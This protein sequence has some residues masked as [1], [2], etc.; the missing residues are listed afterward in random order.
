MSR[1]RKVTVSRLLSSPLAGIC[2]RKSKL[3]ANKAMA[4]GRGSS[5][6]EMSFLRKK[7]RLYPS[8]K[9][10]YGVCA[11]IATYFIG[12]ILL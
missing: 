11:H 3:I 7:S 9:T 4:M 10:D 8:I 5:Q 1:I 12:V 2:Q 6:A